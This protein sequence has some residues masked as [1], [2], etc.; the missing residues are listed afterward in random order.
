MIHN[1]KPDRT[2]QNRELIQE[3]LK[4]LGPGAFSADRLRRQ[5]LMVAIEMDIPT[6]STHAVADLLRELG[7]DRQVSQ[8]WEVKNG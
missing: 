4:R 3:V 7:Y 6:P 2:V 1:P 8:T 5:V